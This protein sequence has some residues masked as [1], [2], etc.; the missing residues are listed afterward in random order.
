MALS[1]AWLLSNKMTKS[2]AWLHSNEMTQSQAWLL[3]KWDDSISSLT[4]KAWFDSLNF[5]WLLKTHSMKLLGFWQRAGL[6][7]ENYVVRCSSDKR[8]KRNT[9]STTAI[10]KDKSAIY[11]SLWYM[12]KNTVAKPLYSISQTQGS[13]NREWRLHDSSSNLHI[14]GD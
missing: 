7:K 12:N 9:A 6:K 10:S 1:Q 4:W 3:F 14:F 5:L 11:K 2:E 13:C 8:K